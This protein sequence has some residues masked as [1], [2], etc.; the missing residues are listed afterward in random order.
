MATKSKTNSQGPGAS[1]GPESA[2]QSSDPFEMWRQLYETNERAWTAALDQAMGRPEFGESSGKM[3]ETMLAAQKAVR[4]N[5]RTY[6]ETIN[7]PTREDI[8]RVGE[9]VV[10]IE[11]KIDQLADRLDAIEDAV[12]GASS[13]RSH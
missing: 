2:R 5:M 12:R 9:L 1:A 11:E 3:L 4:D 10:G 8:A 6:L 7:V 13:K